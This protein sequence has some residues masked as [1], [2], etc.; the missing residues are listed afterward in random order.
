MT[1]NFAISFTAPDLQQKAAL[2]A[3]Q[4]R[5]PVVELSDHLYDFLLVYTEQSLEIRSIKQKD[6]GKFHIDF[7]TG[8][9]GFR[10]AHT[11]I[12]NELIARAV[13]IKGNQ[14]LQLIDA[15]AG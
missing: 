4:L 8:K 1:A 14:S 2:L 13:G 3:H 6:L 5:L 10:R 11:Y 15:T 12:K 9:L 7:L